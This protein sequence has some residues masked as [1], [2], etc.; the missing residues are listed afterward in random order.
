M[1]VRL[2]R[3][4]R[5]AVAGQCIVCQQTQQ[6]PL[7]SRPPTQLPAAPPRPAPILQLRPGLAKRLRDLVEQLLASGASPNALDAPQADDAAVL[8]DATL[9]EDAEDDADLLT[10]EEEE[11]EV[12]GAGAAERERKRRR[13]CARRLGTRL[14]LAAACQSPLRW[15]LGVGW[16]EA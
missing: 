16:E 10:D 7:L 3:S 13:W 12:Q 15:G 9:E 4:T 5:R 11:E 6:L 14:E 2:G 8:I 1:R